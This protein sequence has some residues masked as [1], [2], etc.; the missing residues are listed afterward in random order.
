M[1]DLAALVKG[2]VRAAYAAGFLAE[3]L[4]PAEWTDTD[5]VSSLKKIA[6]ARWRAILQ[7]SEAA[8]GS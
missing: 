2:A 4:H 7:Y 6:S 1:A 3:G 8:R 5:N